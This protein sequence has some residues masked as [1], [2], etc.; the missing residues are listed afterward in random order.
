MLNTLKRLTV[1]NPRLVLAVGLILLIILGVDPA[2]A[3][4]DLSGADGIYVGT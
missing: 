4:A 3:S 2:A 1:R